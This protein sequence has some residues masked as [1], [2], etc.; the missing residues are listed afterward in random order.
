MSNQAHTPTPSKNE[1]FEQELATFEA[2]KKTHVN[3]ETID[4]AREQINLIDQ[5]VAQL[6]RE[7]DQYQRD[8]DLLEV[9]R[10]K[11][12]GNIIEWIPKELQ[13]SITKLT[14]RRSSISQLIKAYDNMTGITREQRVEIVLHGHVLNSAASSNNESN[15]E[16]EGTEFDIPAALLANSTVMKMLKENGIL[17]GNK[18]ILENSEVIEKFNKYKE[19]FNVVFDIERNP[20]TQEIV[21]K[22][23]IK[24]SYV[25]LINE[26]SKWISEDLR[27][28]LTYR[29]AESIYN[30]VIRMWSIIER[31][32]V[33]GEYVIKNIKTD[34]I[35]LA[36]PY[37][38]LIQDANTRNLI[39]VAR[40]TSMI[41]KNFVLN[42]HDLVWDAGLVKHLLEEH[43]ITDKSGKAIVKAEH[44]LLN[45]DS[46]LAQINTKLAAV[47]TWTSTSY[48]AY[49]ELSFLKEYLTSGELQRVGYMRSTLREVNHYKDFTADKALIGGWEER[50]LDNMSEKDNA[51][52]IADALQSS[53]P[54]IALFGV[55]ALFAKQKKTA[56][57]AFIAAIFWGVGAN[58]I[59]WANKKIKWAITDEMLDLVKVS[60][61]KYSLDNNSYSAGYIKLADANSRLA[62]EKYDENHVELPYL[63]NKVLFD[64]TEFLTSN[65]IDVEIEDSAKTTL[66][67]LKLEIGQVPNDF[68]D[69]ELLT[70]IKVV[71]RSDIQDST[72]STLLD[73]LHEG[74]DP[75]NRSYESVDFIGLI[76]GLGNRG[77]K[78]V[79]NQELNTIFRDTYEWV[80]DDRWERKNI[81][82]QRD[83]VR[84][85]MSSRKPL[86]ARIDDVE[87]YLTAKWTMIDWGGTLSKKVHE[88]L[89][90]Y[91]AYQKAE[92]AIKGYTGIWDENVD[93]IS[94]KIAD[95]M[96]LVDYDTSEQWKTSLSVKID[97]KIANLETVKSEIP[98]TYKS[99]PEFVTLINQID[100]IIGKLTAHNELL[101]QDLQIQASPTVLSEAIVKSYFDNGTKVATLKQKIVSDIEVLNNFISNWGITIAALDNIK[102]EYDRL[103]RYGVYLK[104]K[105]ADHANAR[106]NQ[107]QTDIINNLFEFNKSGGIKEQINTRIKEQLTEKFAWYEPVIN[108]LENIDVSDFNAAMQT[109]QEAEEF[110]RK[111]VPSPS[112]LTS[113]NT[114]SDALDVI[115]GSL[116]SAWDWAKQLWNNM[117]NGI[118][119]L[120][121]LRGNLS[122]LENL[123]TQFNELNSNGSISTNVFDQAQE[124]IAAIRKELESVQKIDSENRNLLSQAGS[125]VWTT[126]SIPWGDITLE[127]IRE[128][129]TEA[130]NNLKSKA[131]TYIENIEVSTLDTKAKRDYVLNKIDTIKKWFFNDATLVGEIEKAKVNINL[132][133]PLSEFPGIIWG[134]NPDGIT[135]DIDTL[136]A[137]I[138][139]EADT[140]KED[141]LNNV[142]TLL[143]EIAAWDRS[144][145]TAKEL[146]VEINVI[147]SDQADMWDYV[148]TYMTKIDSIIN[149]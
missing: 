36:H 113:I 4:Y 51:D 34:A 53:R 73:Y 62:G 104:G 119:T 37:L 8:V 43:Q 116:W 139:I 16:V 65:D 31:N 103:W 54:L 141:V 128:K 42:D 75:A 78:E 91:T 33:T 148:W 147:V 40:I 69:D 21:D 74:L 93:A 115:T 97:T 138:L 29:L 20:Q 17:R 86:Q 5:N 144:W 46:V 1:V 47:R 24:D 95:A 27:E 132:A 45:K 6:Q 50:D 58:M 94:Q 63:D 143:S 68:S 146:H 121:L 23:S 10:W 49:Q 112:T 59:R 41:D 76:N 90:A 87:S 77:W 11:R 3:W 13:A 145:I 82:T 35:S 39:D 100:G 114:Y 122:E 19:L 85:I 14:N 26:A 32:G 131:K 142:H 102:T 135:Q 52:M 88:S 110:I 124:T 61:I 66:D 71:Q 133:R 140:D 98:E 67:M 55:L 15:E 127:N 99:R 130:R 12:S 118:A 129:T 120:S 38:D 105:T 96:E 64:I 109:I 30:D 80:G 56:Y 84:K 89:T 134:S 117:K 60:D 83:E 70:Y 7:V 2:T 123:E 25:F 44:M 111:Q 28:M 136:E 72:D 125:I 101:A 57:V 22:Q 18:V 108:N 106:A 126:L 79:F 92:G 48:Q 81:L 107:H 9:V 137:Q 149:N